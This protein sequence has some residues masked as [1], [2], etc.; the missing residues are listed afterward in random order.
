V[1]ACHQTGTTRSRLHGLRKYID[2][3]SR[4]YPHEFTKQPIR[5]LGSKNLRQWQ[6]WKKA[7]NFL[8]S[9]KKFH[10]GIQVAFSA[11]TRVRPINW[12]QSTISGA[13]LTL[14]WIIGNSG[15]TISTSYTSAHDYW[16][17]EMAKPRVDS[18]FLPLIEEMPGNLR[19]S[20]WICAHVVT[21]LRT[22]FLTPDSPTC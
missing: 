14:L 8:P 22:L 13:T 18:M 20:F 5:Y 4:T 12:P 2:L 6:A 3:F 19:E 1:K 7:K 16:L 17:D 10:T 15:Q 11:D 21:T 9:N